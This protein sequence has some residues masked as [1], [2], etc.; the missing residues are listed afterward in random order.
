M[1]AR[2]HA[3]PDELE[4]NITILAGGQA[5]PLRVGVSAQGPRAPNDSVRSPA[6]RQHGILGPKQ[7]YSWSSSHA[8]A[9]V[10]PN[11]QAFCTSAAGCAEAVYTFCSASRLCAP[12]P[13]R[14]KHAA[15]QVMLAPTPWRAALGLA[16][17]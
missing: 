5:W 3:C 14:L 1:V 4:E 15:V 7:K 12:H 17:I 2:S 10:V 13:D 8:Q 11:P 6:V 9:H 16:L